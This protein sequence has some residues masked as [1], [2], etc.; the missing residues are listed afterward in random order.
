MSYFRAKIEDVYDN[1]FQNLISEIYHC[2]GWSRDDA[3]FPTLFYLIQGI[4]A[5]DP[6]AMTAAHLPTA[7]ILTTKI[8]KLPQGVVYELCRELAELK[9]TH[10]ESLDGKNV[11][12][13]I[14]AFLPRASR[15]R[16]PSRGQVRREASTM[17]IRQR[18]ANGDL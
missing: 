4:G 9:R 5:Q 12:S 3:N 2:V 14:K 8:G 13:L 15:R 18:R 7:G 1:D 10:L 11:L 16:S 17:L 6:N